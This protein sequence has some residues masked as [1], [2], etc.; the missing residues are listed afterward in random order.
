[1]R[2]IPDSR[3]FTIADQSTYPIG[4]DCPNPRGWYH[5][6]ANV[7]DTSEGLVAVY[8]LSNSHTAVYTHI[9]VAY[10]K[11]GGRTW[12]WQIPR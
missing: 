11:D 6:V 10:S 2:K 3:K 12:D 4:F 5:S 7:A 9:M 8:R 1:M